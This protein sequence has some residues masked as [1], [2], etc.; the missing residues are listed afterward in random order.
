MKHH[1]EAVADIE[2]PIISPQ[3]ATKMEEKT[4]YTLFWNLNLS[5]NP[6][7]LRCAWLLERRCHGIHIAGWG[8]NDGNSICYN[9]NDYNDF[10]LPPLNKPSL[11]LVP[12]S[13]SNAETMCSNSFEFLILRSLKRRRILIPTFFFFFFLLL[14]P[15]VFLNVR[16]F[17]SKNYRIY[18]SK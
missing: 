4:L 10:C 15:N 12:C 18:E 5:T 3:P 8:K 17:E 9:D 6:L 1:L 11:T 14:S 16:I 2:K 13:I 7:F